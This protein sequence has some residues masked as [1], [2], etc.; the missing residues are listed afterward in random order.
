L[1]LARVGNHGPIE[2]KDLW[3]E[4]IKIPNRLRK[5]IWRNNRIK[6]ES[7]NWGKCSTY[8]YSSCTKFV[9]TKQY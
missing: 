9:T 8:F 2:Q 5:Q 7:S 4:K 1:E 3:Q 6:N